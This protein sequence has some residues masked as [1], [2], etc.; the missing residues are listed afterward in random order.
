MFIFIL[1]LIL[2]LPGV[3]FPLVLK[4]SFSSF[5]LYEMG[6]YLEDSDFMPASYHNRVNTTQAGITCLCT[7]LST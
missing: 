3:L 5:E 7:S 6:V 2:L 4:T 1:I